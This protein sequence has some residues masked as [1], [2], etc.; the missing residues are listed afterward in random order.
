MQYPNAT[1]RVPISQ[2]STN[3]QV[4]FIPLCRYEDAQAIRAVA[5]HPSGKYFAG[6]L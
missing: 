1:A 4:Q 3:Q 2:P 6:L 5:F